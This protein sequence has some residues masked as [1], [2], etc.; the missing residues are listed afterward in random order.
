MVV[1]EEA[2]LWGLCLRPCDQRPL[3]GPGQMTAKV[4]GNYQI[5]QPLRF[6]LV[7]CSLYHIDSKNKLQLLVTLGIWPV[8]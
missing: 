2:L 7:L 1:P 6:P 8:I 5:Y 3:K 4:L